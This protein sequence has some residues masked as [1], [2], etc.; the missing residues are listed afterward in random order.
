[1]FKVIGWEQEKR[2]SSDPRN[3]LRGY[4]KVDFNITRKNLLDVYGLNAKLYVKNLMDEDI[5]E[6]SVIGGMKNDY[7]MPGRNAHIELSYKF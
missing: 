4:H 7:P 2:A 1:M 6:P 3:D 5:R